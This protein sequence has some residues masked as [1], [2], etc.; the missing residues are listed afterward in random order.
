MIYIEIQQNIIDYIEMSEFK[1]YNYFKMNVNF[2][3]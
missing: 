1:I 3:F 2:Q